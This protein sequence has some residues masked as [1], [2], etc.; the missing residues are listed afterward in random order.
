MGVRMFCCVGID[1]R[2]GR[3]RVGKLGGKLG[4]KGVG[5]VGG[6]YGGN[7]GESTG[8]ICQVKARI[9]SFGLLGYGWWVNSCLNAGR[10]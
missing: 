7:I 8:E 2:W 4:V 5:K 1:S 10:I 3:E 6:K 9:F